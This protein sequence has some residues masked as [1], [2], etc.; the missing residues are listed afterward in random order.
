MLTHQPVVYTT[1]CVPLLLRLLLVAFQP[2]INNLY[3]RSKDWKGLML[4]L[5]VTPWLTNV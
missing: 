3:I 4:A 5:F 1:S 2:T